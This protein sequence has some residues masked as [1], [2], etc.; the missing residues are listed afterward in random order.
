MIINARGKAY[1]MFKKNKIMIV[2]DDRD[3][4]EE[5]QEMLSSLGYET[6][7]VFD[8]E[9]ALSAAP[10][11]EPDLILLDMKMEG[12]TGF[13]V[14][15]RLKLYPKTARIPIIMMTGY[16]TRNEHMDLM[17]LY[18]V[19]ACVTKPIDFKNLTT[20]IEKYIAGS[21]KRR[22]KRNKNTE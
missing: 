3:Y 18:G 5:F 17:Q 11:F 12:L 6:V 10:G 13:H 8:G 15:E 22:V 7:G 2:D 20:L 4:V 14:A 1:E 9:T 19:Q 21:N 16:F